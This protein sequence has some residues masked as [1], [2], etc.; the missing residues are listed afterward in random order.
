VREKPDEGLSC[1]SLVEDFK[2]RSMMDSVA[3][4]LST[5]IQIR[6]G[7]ELPP[8]PVASPRSSPMR[9]PVVSEARAAPVGI[10]GIIWEGTPKSRPVI[11][12]TVKV[13]RGVI[14]LRVV[15]RWRRHGR[16][17]V[18]ARRVR[19]EIRRPRSD[20]RQSEDDARS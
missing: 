15:G 17:N 6:T 5:S 18:G 8:V 9:T 1:Q 14:G 13:G 20:R 19:P 7:V 12:G 10:R 11:V 3:N 2:D 16:F 4:L